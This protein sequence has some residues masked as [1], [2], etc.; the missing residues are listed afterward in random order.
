MAKLRITWKRSTIGRPPAQ[1]RV[2]KALGF[3]RLNE[4]VYHEDTPQI[5]GMINKISHLLEWS[6]EE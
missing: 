4:T 3:H 6:A 5:R 1:E 2:I